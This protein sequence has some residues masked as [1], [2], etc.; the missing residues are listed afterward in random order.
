MNYNVGA[1]WRTCSL[2]VFVGL[3]LAEPLCAA[4]ADGPVPAKPAAIRAFCVDF[5]WGPGGPNGFA[6]PGLWADADPQAHVQWYKSL[7]ANVIQTF[8]VSCNGYAWYKGGI[9]PPQPGLKHDFLTDVVQLGHREGMQV[10]GYFC[11]GANTLWGQ[12]HPEQSYGTPSHTHIPFTTQYIDYLCGSVTD[13]L[14]KTSMDGFMVDWFFNGPYQPADSRLKWLPC[15]VQMWSE[16]MGVPF[17]GRDKISVPQE[18]EFKRRAV[19][20][21][22]RRLHAAAK[23]AKPDCVIWLSC[24]DLTH[25]QLVHSKLFKEVDWLMNEAGDIESL[26]SLRSELGPNTRLVTC[27]VGW[28]DRHNARSIIP[29]AQAHGIGI[30]GFSRPGANSLPLPIATYLSKPISA[31]AGNDRNIATLARFYNGLPFDAVK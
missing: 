6:K 29:A 2:L 8:A 24:H 7:G 16:L 25:P 28:G 11:I 22:W 20:R 12:Q 26:E 21:C 10:M 27:V 30:Y 31:F 23:A 4:A 9:V 3:V 15:E 14:V 18:T 13:A 17:P 19:T 5:N 1:C